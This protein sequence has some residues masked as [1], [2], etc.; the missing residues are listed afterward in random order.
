MSFGR[1]FLLFRKFMRD[2]IK[3]GGV[4]G[5]GFVHCL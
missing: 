4:L 5:G 2:D 3:L 1:A